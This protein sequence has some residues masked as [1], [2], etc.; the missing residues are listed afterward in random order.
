MDLAL[1]NLVT[2]ILTRGTT[3]R[4][5]SMVKANTYGDL[6]NSMTVSGKMD[7]NKDL[8]CGRGW[9]VISMLANG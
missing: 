1:K 2:V 9:K 5:G 3:F 8:D 7:S 6:A 4:G